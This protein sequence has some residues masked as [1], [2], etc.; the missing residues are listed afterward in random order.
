MLIPKC[1]LINLFLLSPYR[2]SSMNYGDSTDA[3]SLICKWDLEL[4][5]RMPDVHLPSDIVAS[6]R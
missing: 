4:D 2:P 1:Y 6:V 5:F 3:P